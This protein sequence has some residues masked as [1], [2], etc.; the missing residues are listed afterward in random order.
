M[1][2]NKR[3]ITKYVSLKFLMEGKLKEL[4]GKSDLLI[5]EDMLSVEI[6]ELYNKKLS[7]EEILSLINKNLT[8]EMY[9]SD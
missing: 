6:Y 4:Y 9:K 8:D 2:L 7:E 1:G 5:F 3:Y